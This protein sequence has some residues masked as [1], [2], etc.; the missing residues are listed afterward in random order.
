M[1]QI[2]R[3]DGVAFLRD[4]EGKYTAIT[5]RTQKTEWFWISNP[6]IRMIC[7][8]AVLIT[9]MLTGT[10]EKSFAVP[11][12]VMTWVLRGSLK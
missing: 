3:K 11:D 12:K 7:M 4:N 5:F 8:S 2:S 9:A 10:M 1:A 6:A